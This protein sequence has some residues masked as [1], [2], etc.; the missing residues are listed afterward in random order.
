MAHTVRLAKFHTM[1]LAWKEINLKMEYR[2]NSVDFLK[3]FLD[4]LH[5]K[6]LAI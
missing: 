4:R 5:F 3:P 2:K 1:N 6:K